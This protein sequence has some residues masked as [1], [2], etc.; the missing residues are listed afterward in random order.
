VRRVAIVH[1]VAGIARLEVV[2]LRDAGW[3]VDFYELPAPGARW[4]FW[5][6]ALVLPLR[7]VLSLPVM[8]RLRRGHYDLVHVHFV[9]Q[10]FVGAGSGRPY[11]L[12]AHGSDL[13]LN[14]GNPILRA[15]S[16]IWMR[17]ARRIFYVTPNLEPY[18]AEFRDKAQLLPNPVDTA[19]FRAIDPP[20]RLDKA[21][22]FVRLDPI[23]GADSVFAV[24]DQL[25]QLVSLSA[26]DWGSLAGELKSRYG[27]RVQFLKPV[28]PDSVAEM[29]AGFD[30]VIG[31]MLQ[32][33]L[34]LSELE[35][36]A[37]GRVV[38]M[39]LD[40]NLVEGEAPPVVNV[41]SGTAL[42]DRVRDLQG[43]ASEVQRLSAAGRAWVERHHGLR[44]HAQA[45]IDCYRA[46]IG[47]AH[48]PGAQ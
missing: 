10:G 18:L 39:R 48:P 40:T 47:D 12:H 37:A 20:Q 2:A 29:L 15:W 1:D 27:E 13:H 42:V 22:L 33:V 30:A 5:L 34:G 17:G 7:V 43:D 19:R 3:D 16:R 45:L 28:P 9:S 8:L 24:S 6:K 23:K 4:P 46:V 38:L 32:G 35:A 41:A 11:F 44:A 14:L 31:Q 36:L 26:I 25:T 21:L